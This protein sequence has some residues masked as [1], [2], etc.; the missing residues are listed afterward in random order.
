MPHPAP[1]PIAPG[2]WTRPSHRARRRTGSI[3][4]RA[5]LL[6]AAASAPTGPSPPSTPPK[7]ASGAS[8]AGWGGV[9]RGK[10]VPAAADAAASAV[11]AAVA[12]QLYGDCIRVAPPG[13][14]RRHRCSYT[15]GC[16]SPL[17]HWRSAYSVRCPAWA[18]WR[19]GRPQ[20]T[21]VAVA[22][23]LLA[24]PWTRVPPLGPLWAA[25]PRTATMLVRSPAFPI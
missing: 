25:A 1:R 11:R 15:C 3:P 18:G 6:A 14:R 17:A 24:P 22:T 20:E 13:R 23:P 2:G 10:K 19:R 16:S 21:V 12:W 4:A 8:A 5:R 7:W 9:E